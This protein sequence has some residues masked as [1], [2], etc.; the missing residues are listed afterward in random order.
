MPT[1]TPMLEIAEM[2]A[3]LGGGS[4]QV[5]MQCGTCTAVCPWNLVAENNPRMMLRQ[6]SL[7]LEGY[8]SEDVWRCV[9]CNLCVA[10]C[11]RGVEI[12]DVI[13]STRGVMI[14]SGSVPATYKGPLASLHGEGNPWQGDR[15]ERRVVAEELGLEELHDGHQYHYFTCCSQTYDPRN[16]RVA[17]ALA[18]LLGVAGVS[19]GVRSDDQVCCGDQARKV[20]AEELFL[21]LREIN[22]RLL[23]SPEVSKV[24]TVSPHCLNVIKHDCAEEHLGVVV[25]H[26]TQVLDHALKEGR[27]PLRARVHKRVTYHD[28]CYLGRHNGVYDA[29]RNLLDAID[30]LTRVEMRHSRESSLCCGGGGGGLWAD[31]PIEKRFAVMRVREALSVDAEVIATACPH[32][33]SM[34]EDA[35]KVLDLEERITVSD[36]A[37]LLAE[38]MEL[39]P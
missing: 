18:S 22:T 31:V 19:F 37:E 14:D 3:E 8:E 10:R 21:E 13:R 6:I 4:L 35:V 17:R 26:Y 2:V 36:V 5:C 23:G 29:P 38:S 33:I 32:C 24:L 39:T 34:L 7:G 28:P 20:G 27:L 11:P 12:I 16:R 25:E 9:T 15:A 1:V 30:G